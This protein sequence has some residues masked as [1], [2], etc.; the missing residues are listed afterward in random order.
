MLGVHDR[1]N[2][3]TLSMG[4]LQ[5]MGEAQ[6]TNFYNDGNKVGPAGV[7]GWLVVLL[8]GAGGA[9][10]GRCSWWAGLTF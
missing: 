4:S 7:A 1:R 5:M 8:R 3:N 9:A 2:A 10:G 6:L